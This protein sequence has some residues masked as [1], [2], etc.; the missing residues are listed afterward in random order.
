MVL[1]QSSLTCSMY[2][3]FR[4]VVDAFK[5]DTEEY[6]IVSSFV[7]CCLK[8]VMQHLHFSH[9]TK[10]LAE[11]RATFLSVLQK[12]AEFSNMNIC[13]RI[14]NANQSNRQNKDEKIF[15]HPD[16]FVERLRTLRGL[17]CHNC[18]DQVKYKRCK[19]QPQASEFFSLNLGS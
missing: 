5:Y 2:A 3:G 10:E 17:F 15:L 6:D 19:Y 12:S 13:D 16:S 14:S 1:L 11:N 8:K 4:S 18:V 7:S 9:H